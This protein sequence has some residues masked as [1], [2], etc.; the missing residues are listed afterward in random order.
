MIQ[1]EMASKSVGLASMSD[2]YQLRWLPTQMVTNSDGMR[3]RVRVKVRV[4]VRV[5]VRV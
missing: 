2:G 3:M 4:W 5:R 1:N